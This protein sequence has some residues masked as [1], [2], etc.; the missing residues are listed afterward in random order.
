MLEFQR[1]RAKP[2][3]IRSILYVTSL[4]F[5]DSTKEATIAF[6]PV[7]I[8]KHEHSTIWRSKKSKVF[9]WEL[10][11]KWERTSFELCWRVLDKKWPRQATK[12]NKTRERKTVGKA[13]NLNSIW[14]YVTL[15]LK[16]ASTFCI[17]ANVL[18]SI[19]ILSLAPFWANKH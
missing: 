4:D 9:A 14:A 5:V 16:K 8:E 15:K 10:K 7:A 17:L 6:T 13:D 11:M 1:N 19:Y 2:E 3:L 18:T 12:E